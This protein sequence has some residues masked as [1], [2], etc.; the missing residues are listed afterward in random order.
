MMLTQL[1]Y[2]V[3]A[4]AQDA[5]QVSD[6]S[7]FGVNTSDSRAAILQNFRPIGGAS[8]GRWTSQTSANIEILRFECPAAQQCFSHPWKAEFVLFQGRLASASFL[9]N[10]ENG[11]MD[12]PASGVVLASLRALGFK[13]A[14]AQKKQVGRR[15]R[16]FLKPKAT[17]VW[18]QDGPDAELKLYV[19][20]HNP[21]GRA[22]AVAAGASAPLDGYPGAAEYASAQRELANRQYGKAAA[23]LERLLALQT[24]S[25]LLHREAKLVLAMV[26]ASTVTEWLKKNGTDPIRL[27]RARTALKR[28]KTLAPDLVVY[29]NQLSTQLKARKGL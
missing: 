12:L 8:A 16:Y 21:L 10:R 24:V 9:L 17:V 3:I 23:A 25:P 2:L 22:E 28:A 14:D 20:A 5:S 27:K 19:D 13:G 6:T 26:L 18:V 15:T 4:L 7:L 29:L 11:P 1:L